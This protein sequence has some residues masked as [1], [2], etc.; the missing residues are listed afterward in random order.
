VL[1]ERDLPGLDAGCQQ[2]ENVQVKGQ[3]DR[4]L[5]S[6]RCPWSGCPALVSL[7]RYPA[8]NE[9]RFSV[10]LVGE[11]IR[12]FTLTLWNVYSFFVTYANLDQWTPPPPNP[13]PHNDEREGLDAWLLSKLHA[14]VRDVTTA[15]ETYDVPGATPAD[16]G[17]RGR[18]VKM[19]PAPFPPPVLEIG[20]R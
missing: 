4:S 17:I 12:N 5:G 6:D 3:Y 18:S 9:R 11:V 8:R 20:S 19:V 15:F 7:H 16:P 13:L 1:Q 10:D 2:R 14:L